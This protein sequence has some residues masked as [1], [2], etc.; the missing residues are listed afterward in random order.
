M[1]PVVIIPTF[2]SGVSRARKSSSVVTTYDHTT[3][4][5]EAGELDRCLGSLENVEGM[6]LILV[7]LCADQNVE[8]Q[9][10]VKVQ[11]VVN[12]HP[13]LEVVVIAQPELQAVR[14]H[15]E[16]KGCPPLKHEVAL[17]GYGAIRNLGLLLANVLGFDAVVFLDD[18]ELV[19]DPE[20]LKKAMYGLGKRT[21]K[22]FPILAKSGYY[23]NDKGTYLSEWEDKWYNRFWQKGS[24]FNE[25]IQAAMKRPRLS[26]SNH[27]CGGIMSIHKDA[28]QSMP[29]DAWIPR[30][31]DLD[32]LLDLRM[33]GSD[34]WFDNQWVVRHLPPHSIGEGDRFRQ[35]I[36]RWLYEYTKLEYSRALIDLH[37]VKPSS[38]EPYPGPFL[39]PGLMNRIRITAL[40]RSFA[41]PDKQA[42]RRAAKSA[43]NE[44]RIYA[45]RNCSK[46]YDFQQVWS[47]VM[48]RLDSDS[49]LAGLV[50]NTYLARIGL[51][52]GQ[53]VAR[54]A[55]VQPAAAASAVAQ[56]QPAGVASAVAQPQPVARP[57]NVQPAVV[58]QPQ[59]AA[60]APVVEAR[61]SVPVAF[62][63]PVASEAVSAASAV[64][65]V[66]LDPEAAAAA[67]AQR[68]IAAALAERSSIDPGLT[69]EIRLNVAE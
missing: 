17:Q 59:P 56:P 38:L 40:L 54:P 69:S 65:A 55:S 25:W 41:R 51:G 3:N 20:F 44:A 22:G 33:Y 26:R 5:H 31:E 16:A 27:V 9:A 23:L 43:A 13:S 62:G 1:K 30:G 46:Y 66:E 37:P 28:F 29:F 7:L 42:Y 52:A 36:F 58:A 68:A 39:E 6:G 34:V 18:D 47:D 32:Y 57:A 12:A 14:Q 21:R 63:A 48:D 11:E 49:E 53:P 64:P 24:A 8:E 50:L 67:V 19:E 61:Q 2:I 4:I 45:T 35:N 15:L 60:A 10:Q